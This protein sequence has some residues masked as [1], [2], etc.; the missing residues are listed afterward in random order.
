MEYQRGRY[1]P[2]EARKLRRVLGPDAIRIHD[3]GSTG[4][5]GQRKSPPDLHSLLPRLGRHGQREKSYVAGFRRRLAAQDF[6][7]THYPRVFLQRRRVCAET[8]LPKH[9]CCLRRSGCDV[10]GQAWCEFNRRG[11]R[12]TVPRQSEVRLCPE[13]EGGVLS[14]RT[15]RKGLGSYGGDSSAIYVDGICPHIGSLEAT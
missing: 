9:Q 14:S 8:P 15:S 2:E 7:R 10:E 12:W 11:G 13:C 3:H 4:E 1:G 6:H 5:A